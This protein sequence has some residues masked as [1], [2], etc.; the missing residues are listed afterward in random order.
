MSQG[1]VPFINNSNQHEVAV[2]GINILKTIS[3]IDIYRECLEMAEF[4]EAKTKEKVIDE[5]EYL[6]YLESIVARDYYPNSN[7]DKQSPSTSRF[8]NMMIPLNMNVDTYL[9]NF[10]SDELESIKDI[11][12]KDNIKKLKKRLWMYKEEVKSKMK[13]KDKIIGS[14]NIYGDIKAKN[15]LFFVPLKKQESSLLLGK[16]R[17]NDDDNNNADDEKKIANEN[18]RFPHD[19][20]EKME[21][22]HNT[23]VRKKL[24]EMYENSDLVKLMKE[25]KEDKVI[26]GYSLIKENTNNNHKSIMP[27]VFT[28]GEIASTPLAI[29]ETTNLFKVPET[30]Q[31]DAIAYDLVNKLNSTNSELKTKAKAN[32]SNQSSLTPGGLKLLNSIKRNNY[33]FNRNNQNSTIP[34]PQR[35]FSSILIKKKIED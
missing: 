6:D 8:D 25:M 33:L 28:W 16:K 2:K 3:D 23:S 32:Q 7:K 17:N 10:A 21:E 12:S 29:K 9:A 22:E 31:R 14:D 5:D 15:P 18:T 19:F 11:I 35:R 24:I 13:N 26:N 27:L 34:T 4:K 20:V 1:I 30:P